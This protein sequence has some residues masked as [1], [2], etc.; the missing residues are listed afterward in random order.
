MQTTTTTEKRWGKVCDNQDNGQIQLQVYAHPILED[1]TESPYIERMYGRTMVN[2]HGQLVKRWG[3]MVDEYF[4]LDSDIQYAP[5]R[6]DI[7]W[8]SRI[9]WLACYAVTGGSEGHYVHIDALMLEGEG[10]D[11]HLVVRPLFLGKTFQGMVHA[12]A[13]AAKCA[14]LLGA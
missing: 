6:A 8:P 9:R 4:H 7:E 5:N 11:Q 13:I 14:E 3:D 2:I 10:R 12:Q 1:G